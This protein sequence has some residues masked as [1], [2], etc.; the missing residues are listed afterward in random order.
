MSAREY[1]VLL[2]LHR[3]AAGA[4]DGETQDG[5]APP[6]VPGLRMTHLAAR[7]VLSKSAITTLVDRVERRGLVARRAVP[8]DRRATL[9]VITDAGE[10]AFLR[11]ATIHDDVV[12]THFSRDLSGPEA[13]TMLAALTRVAE[14]LRDTKRRRTGS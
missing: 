7:L 14:G 3:L 1:Q 10:E 9:V 4:P 8:D 6:P 11:A 5:S 2:H 13:R 12:A